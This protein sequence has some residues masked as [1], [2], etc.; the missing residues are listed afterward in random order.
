VTAN[1]LLYLT[2]NGV[3]AVCLTLLIA[4][5]VTANFLLYLTCNG[6]LAVCLTLLIAG[7]VAK[8]KTGRSHAKPRDKPQQKD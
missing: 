5:T 8:E 3:L 6:V 4:G 7:T 1:F 2:C